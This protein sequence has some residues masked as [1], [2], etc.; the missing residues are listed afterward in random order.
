[1]SD[2][3]VEWDKVG[4]RFYEIGVDHGMIYP[5][6]NGAYNNGEAWSGLSNVSINPEGA[7]VN[8]IW[9]DNMKYLSLRSAETVKA[10]IECYS[11]PD[12]FKECNGEVSPVAGMTVGQQ[13]RKAFGFSFRSKIGNDEQFQDYGYKL[14]FIYN[15]TA[16]P[17][18][19]SYGTINDSTDVDAMSYEIDTTAIPVKI[20][21]VE[22]KPTSYVC[23]ESNKV[24][25]AENLTAL[26]EIIYGTAAIYTK[27]A[28]TTGSPAADTQY[29][30][31]DASG[32]YVECTKPL[33]AFAANTDYYTLTSAG[34]EP[35]MPLPDEI[36]TII[37]T[38]SPAQG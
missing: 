16:S 27:V 15:A 32:N 26:E 20:N 23:I 35:R 9:A 11:Y 13:T 17:S 4:E 2:Y 24:G 36:Y 18:E 8:D 1:M 31:R 30:T 12:K 5:L 38:G 22:Y 3:Y 19:K 33:T 6:A 21:G 7:D 10:T 37:T 14:H 25:T 29:Y 34:V 28:D